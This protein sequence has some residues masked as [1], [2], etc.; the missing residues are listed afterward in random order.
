MNDPNPKVPAVIRPGRTYRVGAR[1]VVNE[2]PDTEWV[3]ASELAATFALSHA[4]TSNTATLTW[5]AVSGATSY[6]V[7]L[8]DGDEIDVLQATSYEFT[9]LDPARD[10]TLSVR[11]AYGDTARSS[12]GSAAVMTSA[13]VMAPL[14][15]RP[16]ASFGAFDPDGDYSVSVSWPS[17]AGAS[18]YVASFEGKVEDGTPSVYDCPSPASGRKRV[19]C[20]LA[21]DRAYEIVVVAVA[22]PTDGTQAV[23]S[24]PSRAV[25]CLGPC[26]LRVSGLTTS[27]LRL[28]W[29]GLHPSVLIHNVRLREGGRVVQES[30]TSR[31][32]FRFSRL[33]LKPETTYRAEVRTLYGGARGYT[34]W[35][36]LEFTTPEAPA[37][38]PL[39]L[40]VTPSA[41]SCL[42][43][44]TVEISWSVTGGSGRYTVSLDGA[45]QTDASAEVTCQATAGTQTVSLV[46]GDTVHTTLTAT[47]SISLT[48]TAP[49][50]AAPSGLSVVAD[51]TALTLSWDEVNG[52]TG[53]GVRL[54]GGA[55]TK[56]TATA[57]THSF[58]GLQPST[59]Y[60][61]SVRAYVGTDHS[62]WSNIEEA[63]LD[64][65]ALVLTASLSA[66][67]CETGAAVTVSW[68][69]T[70]G[71]G[72]H[73]VTVD[74]VEQSG[75]ST[76]VTCR[77]TAGS[78]NVI[79]TAT[80]QTYAQLRTTQTLGLTVTAP[81]PATTLTAQV[82]ARRLADNRVEFRLRPT[83]GTELEIAQRY[84]KLPEITAGRWYSSGDFTTTVDGSS[85]TLGVIS[86][87]LD[88]T[89]C[90]GQVEV[91]FIHA[92]GD[93]ITPTR[94]KLA[95]NRAADS[96]AVTS[97]F[98]IPLQS[99]SALRE[100][101]Q[102]SAGHWMVESPEGAKDGPGRDGGFMSGDTPEDIDRLQDGDT[103]AICTAQPTG[104][105]A[106][107]LTSSG[108]RLSWQAVSGASEYDVSVGSGGAASLTS[109]QLQYD[110]SGLTADTDHTL[111]VRARS[112]QGSSQWSSTTA[113][114]KASSVPVIT[115][116]A[117]TSPVAEGGS[118]SF[119]V[120]SDRQWTAA[121]TVQ[122]TVSESG[123]MIS[124]SLPTQVTIAA[125]AQ[126]ATVSVATED[127]KQDESDNVVTVTLLAG[128][129]YRLGAASSATVTVTDNDGQV[130]TLTASASP[131]SCVTDGQV[132]VSWTVT[133][134][135]GSYTVTVD[136]VTQT[137]A[138]ATVI[139]Q[140]TVGTQTVTLT[141]IDQT[142]TQLSTT[143]SL[144]L[145]VV[146]PVTL[147]ASATPTSCE[148]GGQVT[149]SWTVAGGS[150]SYTAT[151]DGAA[152]T[153]ASAT[154]TCQATAGTQ[155][156]T[157]K[158][159]D[160][161]HTQLSTTK[162]LTLTVVDPVT[163]TASAA[164]MSCETGGQ[165]TVSWTAGGGSGSHSV[166]VDGVAQTGASATVTCQATAGTQ[167]VAVTAT[168][169]VHTQL[170]VTQTL[171]LTVTEPAP[172]STVEAQLRARRL[173]D[174]RFELDLR[175]TGH[176]IGEITKRFASPPKMT[177]GD[178]R[179][180]ES[181]SI[182]IDGGDYTLGRISVRLQND[183]CP[184]RLEVTFL[185]A[186]GDR[187]LPMARFLATNVK[188]ETWFTSRVF[189]ITLVAESSDALL[190][191]SDGKVTAEAWLDDTPDQTNAGPGVEGGL[192]SG[193]SSSETQADEALPGTQS[194]GTPVCP[195]A[196]GGLAA[197]S[198]SND[199]LT[200]S[201]T[202][203]L[204]ASQYDVQR[205]SVDVGSVQA[206]SYQ[207]S[208][209]SPKTNYRFRVR[210]RD[211]WGASAWSSLSITTLP[212]PP[213]A[214]TNLQVTA[215]RSSLKLTWTGS[216][217]ATG[218]QVR[219]G[220]GAVQTLGSTAQS[221]TFSSLTANREYTLHVRATN[222]GGESSWV[223]KTEKTKPLPLTLVASVSP[224]SCEPGDAVTVSWTVT[225]GSGSYAVTVDGV[226]QTGS[227]AK[228]TCQQAAGRQTIAVAS[229]DTV[230]T[231]LR[232]SQSLPVT[233]VSPPTVSGQVAARLLSSGKIEFG[234]R[235]T[236]GSRI[237]PRLRIYTPDTTKLTK[238]TSTSEVYGPAGTERNRLLGKVTVKHIKTTTGYY[239]DVC[240]LAA[241]ASQRICP[242]SNNFYYQTATVDRWLYTGTVRFTPLRASALS[243]DAR[244]SVVQDEQMQAA[245]PG[246]GEAAGSEGGLM[247]DQE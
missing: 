175:I 162:S 242:S 38:E 51:V 200:L 10:Y 116:T 127:D 54:D 117:G 183:R 135:S 56:L 178:W 36:R 137:S 103:Q 246:E 86:A 152:Q 148:T 21:P 157:V 176:A 22:T 45:E 2:A 104:L 70:G 225:G 192:M 128:S 166:T 159:T 139:C 107:N 93:R 161:T 231:S 118:A 67:T 62:R 177:D 221:Y 136:G 96:W 206:N 138:S 151:V 57:L 88:N 186:V 132:T 146:D 64:P 191:S 124:G 80:D 1:L 140:A 9:D 203:V 154:V 66:N 229:S 129:G 220:N 190:D 181:L 89:V 238:W 108:A 201:W 189:E 4:V 227:S 232:A 144:T 114:T 48:V 235:P 5:G 174:N 164:P 44:E 87:R 78:Q 125:G 53:Y 34:P 149:V 15:P 7:R 202:A 11:A 32:W 243:A 195:A 84:L 90:P 65:P 100:L 17:V 28:D 211:A 20:N 85:Y 111:R 155:T 115:I 194:S 42:T 18:S 217:R 172:P 69:T 153:G 187:I 228:V 82:R 193:E 184:S 241:G 95:V 196:P 102:S 101:A 12:W 168:D 60:Q 94:Y 97:E 207:A 141:A 46:A 26:G 72:S 126:S 197:S 216:A 58:S 77:A 61:L 33:S 13:A 8:D 233:V 23:S 25:A 213:P 121:L 19:Y 150:G 41:A 29:E 185:P 208:G 171:S 83:G 210:T 198:V 165:V 106:S 50:V 199:R 99:S 143:K 188:A 37:P 49:S 30:A 163:L 75:S 110:F 179:Q 91:T 43:G 204:G 131:T 52:A 122:L 109:A 169:A 40:T 24:D 209:L 39:A 79:I 145:T 224:S 226:A 205:G 156:V 245:A 47:Q 120:S 134:G 215:T 230:H 218:Y 222:S 63:T 76:A 180:S 98:A 123:S 73:S 214:P 167:S 158:A 219:S 74:G 170:S 223:S 112:W 3:S 6:I 119:T 68:T 35:A 71:S 133:G 113:R 55:E 182:T 212:L 239:V 31:R 59:K 237:L 16:T 244:Q 81:A 14:A 130:I 105:Q 247:S 173:T 147:T 240:F 92:G 142:D 27:G 160:Q 236:G 234:F